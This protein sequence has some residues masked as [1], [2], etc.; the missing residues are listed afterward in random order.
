MS[1]WLHGLATAFP[2]RTQSNDEL[3]AGIAGWTGPRIEAKTGIRARRVAAA[4]ETAGD[5]CARAAERLFAERQIDRSTIDALIVCTQSPDYL[6]P[7]TA[8]LL[9]DRLQLPQTCAA[10]DVTLGC[11]G[12]TYGLWLARSLV[13]SQSAR[14]VL[15]LTGD[16]YTKY[17][18]PTDLAVASLF[19]DGAAASLITDRPEQAWAEIGPSVLGTDG[20]GAPHLIVPVGGARQPLATP[21]AERALHMNGAEIASFAVSTIKPLLQRLLD[22]LGRTWDEVEHFVFHQANPAFV[23]RLAAAYRLPL[24]KVPVGLADIGNTCSATIP[25]LLEECVQTR[26]FRPGDRLLLAGFGVGYSW[27]ATALEWRV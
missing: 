20:R 2:E 23:Q 12:Y 11:S 27:A 24:E 14:N 10:F 13:L 21:E 6:L 26:R 4:E 1:A 16:T 3:A 8:C 17:C 5:L 19:G 15:L 18:R 7:S 9:Q 22:K 25:M